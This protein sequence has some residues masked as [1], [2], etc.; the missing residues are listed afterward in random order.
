MAWE[1]DADTGDW[2][3]T[4]EDN[5]DTQ[6]V[7][8]DDGY[9]E[10]APTEEQQAELDAADAFANNDFSSVGRASIGSTTDASGNKTYNF[11]DGS[12]I[13]KDASGAVTG[14][15]GGE[16]SKSWADLIKNIPTKVGDALKKMVVNSDGS[17]NVSGI[18][19]GLKAL[20]TLGL[21]SAPN[22]AG[23]NVPIPELS[24]TRQQVMPN[25]PNR[26]PGS[27]GLNY[28]TDPKYAKLGDA[29]AQ[30][31]AG[32]ADT[33]QAAGIRAAYTPAVAPAANPYAGKMKPSFL[34]TTATNPMVPTKT[35]AEE[36]LAAQG[37][38]IPGKVAEA[39]HQDAAQQFLFFAKVTLQLAKLA[40]FCWKCRQDP[41]V[42][43]PPLFLICLQELTV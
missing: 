12:T 4:G 39:P 35:A 29:S 24:M 20:A 14:I 7:N 9:Y 40:T 16:T 5:G 10:T 26:R 1:Q 33:A 3:Y 22:Q 11:P 6:T 34:T 25:D 19:N 41:G 23:Y 18:G 30:S 37:K 42:Q 17:L 36:A 32:A 27:G 38:A 31:A 2:Y 8:V 15:T 28:F 21:S 13:T 43:K